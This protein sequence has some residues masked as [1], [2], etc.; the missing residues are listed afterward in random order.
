MYYERIEDKNPLWGFGEDSLHYIYL[1]ERQRLLLS[2]V[3]R[4]IPA[5]D[6]QKEATIDISGHS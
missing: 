3:T 4:K 6:K 5:F 1:E 2:G